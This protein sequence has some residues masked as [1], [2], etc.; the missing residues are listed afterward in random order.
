M[1]CES[2]SFFVIHGTCKGSLQI[3]LINRMTSES[4]KSV[5]DKRSMTEI[6]FFSI[7]ESQGLRI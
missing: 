6:F 1:D 7:K 2:F 4:G 5:L 3:K